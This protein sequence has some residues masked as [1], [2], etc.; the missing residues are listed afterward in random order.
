MIIFLKKG[1]FYRVVT[2]AKCWHIIADK[3]HCVLNDFSAI[4]AETG[5]LTQI[6]SDDILEVAHIEPY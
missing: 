6:K 3:R 5:A 4:D 1:N 2:R